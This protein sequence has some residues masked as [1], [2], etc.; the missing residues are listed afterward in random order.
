[1]LMDYMWSVR[2]RDPGLK[3][4]G[5]KGFF[6]EDF[7]RVNQIGSLDSENC[8]GYFTMRLYSWLK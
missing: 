8:R 2:E 5:I 7:I 4:S 1:M 3:N 6:V